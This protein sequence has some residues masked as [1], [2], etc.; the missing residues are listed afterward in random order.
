MTFESSRQS[1]D[2][3]LARSRT[4]SRADTVIALKKRLASHH[5]CSRIDHGAV[6]GQLCV[7]AHR[8]HWPHRVATER[9]AYEGSGQHNLDGAPCIRWVPQVARWS[10][11]PSADA[12]R[13]MTAAFVTHPICVPGV[14]DC[15]RSSVLRRSE[16]L[17]G[18]CCLHSLRLAGI[19]SNPC[20]RAVTSKESR[21]CRGA[22]IDNSFSFAAHIFSEVTKV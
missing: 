4:L 20:T 9:P 6:C 10:Q 18:S 22:R 1:V 8:R 11:P 13:A 17:Y 2:C 5:S 15:A 19:C 7:W 14:G 3:V 21:E 12:T 16:S